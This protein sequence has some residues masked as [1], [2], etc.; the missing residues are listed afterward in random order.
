MK[1]LHRSRKSEPK[2][3]L[4]FVAE[5]LFPIAPVPIS[6][7]VSV[8]FRPKEHHDACNVFLFPRW[9]TQTQNRKE[10]KVVL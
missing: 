7:F 1:V 6:Q 9:N 4:G 10:I 2:E 3:T 5:R 8:L